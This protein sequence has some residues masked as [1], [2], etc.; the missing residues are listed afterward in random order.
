MQQ[1]S[2]EMIKIYKLKIWEKIALISV[3]LHVNYVCFLKQ[4]QD[5]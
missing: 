1:N 3:T 2:L 4:A 5:G